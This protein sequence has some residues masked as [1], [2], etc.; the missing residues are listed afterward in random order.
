MLKSL[1]FISVS[2]KEYDNSMLKVEKKK[3]YHQMEEFLKEYEH[4]FALEEQATFR[5]SL[6]NDDQAF[7]ITLNEVFENQRNENLIDVKKTKFI[8]FIYS[9]KKRMLL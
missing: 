3:E 7:L 2:K 8:N 1:K 6:E 9:R 4:E 5:Y